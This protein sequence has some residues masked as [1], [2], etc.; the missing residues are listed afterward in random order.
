MRPKSFWSVALLLTVAT[1][2]ASAA[3]MGLQAAQPEPER[4]IHVEINGDSG[5]NMNLNLPLAAI[6]A[7]IAL[8]PNAI[9]QDGQLQLGAESEVSVTAI[10][11]MW[12]E[13]QEAGDTEF[14]T[15][16]REGQNVRITRDVNTIHVDVTG[17]DG[18]ASAEVR[19]EIPVPVVD[20]LLSG[21]GDAL[22]VRAAIKELSTLCGEMVR[23]IEPDNSVRIWIDK[24]PTQ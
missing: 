1:F 2:V 18:D 17:S 7:A 23:V 24:S 20:A 22:N 16:Q 6:E 11:A 8:A 4:W 5:E 15:I 21:E 13:L 9:V 19:V 12:Q 10:R 3:T 14:I